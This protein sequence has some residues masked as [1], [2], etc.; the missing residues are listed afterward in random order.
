MS[1]S[2]FNLRHTPIHKK[3]FVGLGGQALVAT[4]DNRRPMPRTNKVEG[5]NLLLKA[6]PN[7]HVQAMSWPVPLPQVY[8]NRQIKN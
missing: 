1:K 3:G 5:E 4:P 2:S 8:T 6:V 7:L